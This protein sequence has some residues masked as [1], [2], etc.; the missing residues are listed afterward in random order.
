MAARP[1]NWSLLTDDGKDPVAGD[2]DAVRSQAGYYATMAKTII[3]EA[4]RLKT[5]G[6]DDELV[7][8][9]AKSLKEELH[10]LADEVHKAH[11]RYDGVA[12]ALKPY[13]TALDTAKAGSMSALRDAEHA[14]AAQVKAGA[15]PNPQATPGG[16]PLTADQKNQA[17]SHADAVK[18]ANDALNAA[19]TKLHGVL[20]DLNDAGKRAAG[21]IN[22]H[23]DDALKDHHHWWDVVVKIIKVIVELANYAVIVLAVL[24]LFIPGLNVLGIIFLLSAAIL[25][26][27]TILAATGNGSWLDVGVDFIALIT[28]GIGGAA[29]KGGEYAAASAG[30]AG[31][32]AYAKEIAEKGGEGL[33]KR[34]TT[35]LGRRAAGKTYVKELMKGAGELTKSGDALRVGDRGMAESL[36]K[37]GALG[38]R[39]EGN[40]KIASRTA[41]AQKCAG[42]TMKSFYA[43]NVLVGANT[44]GSGSNLPGLEHIPFKPLEG[45]KEATTMHSKYSA[46]EYTWSPTQTKIFWGGIGVVSP[47]LG[48]AGEG[49]SVLAGG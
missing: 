22:D 20:T 9:Y 42:L 6:D 10:D 2:P 27:D 40:A 48:A 36:H 32:K 4:H 49:I 13:A 30:R 3:D 46:D 5:L 23:N 8:K 11:K 38:D 18:A 34:T 43:G 24:S 15:S 47:P 14:Q 39:F 45:L 33:F 17:K 41:F 28:C 37:L 19:K 7:G 29:A 44:I 21:S 31:V 16:K 26:T 1:G 35:Y 12:T 25:L